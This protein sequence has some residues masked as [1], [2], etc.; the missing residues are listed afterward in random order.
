MLATNCQFI[1]SVKGSILGGAWWGRGVGEGG[2]GGAGDA[3][4]LPTAWGC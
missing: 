4:L 1:D 3:A 2:G